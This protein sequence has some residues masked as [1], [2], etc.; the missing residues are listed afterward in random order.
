MIPAPDITILH[1][2]AKRVAELAARDSEPR[3][4]KNWTRLDGLDA[5][6]RP[7]VLV[8]LWQ[9][10]WQE[11]LPDSTLQ[12]ESEEARWLER[13]LRQRIWMAE[14]VDDDGVIEPVAPYRQHGWL[15]PY[16][17]LKVEKR[18]AEDTPH[19]AAEFVPVIVEKS[20]IEKLGNPFLHF[21]PRENTRAKETAQEAFAD[22]LSVV[23]RPWYFAAKVAD[24]FSWLRGLQNTYLDVV[25]DP[26]WVHEALQRIAANFR[27]RFQLLEEAGLWGVAHK[28]APLGSAGLRFAPGLPDWRTAE[29]PTAF[30]PK[31][32]DSWGFTCAEVFNCVSPAMHDEFAFEYD[33]QLMGLFRHINVGCCEVLDRKVDQIRSLPNARKVSV[34]EWCDVERAAAAL[35]PDFVYSYRAAGV[36]FVRE[37]WDREGAETE[38]RAVRGAARGCPLEIVLNI[39][40][41][42]GEGD[43]GRKLAEW[44]RMVRDLL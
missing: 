20:D 11:V 38:I 5:T 6:V 10:S 31:L 33:R 36:H 28:S 24:E 22:I 4:I 1:D 8:H 32:A 12:C 40:G 44:C 19:G 16:E 41:T 17:G 35:G 29:D 9:L 15:T 26:A 27:K 34:S 3:K 7:Q 13:D 18:W 25:E 23:K 30:A 2:L 39:G 42:L 37:P 43:P 14:N 21:D